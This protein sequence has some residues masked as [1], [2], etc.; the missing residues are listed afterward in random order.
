MLKQ[1]MKMQ[2]RFF[3]LLRNNQKEFEMKE[4]LYF[5]AKWCGPCKQLSPV[6]E[7]LSKTYS[8][9]LGQNYPIKKIDIDENP[10][11][12]EKFNVKGVP[13]II[14]IKDGNEQSRLVGLNSKK[15]YIEEF[16][17]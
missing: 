12:T 17:K 14:I 16:E 3:K 5:T 11:Y 7:E 8:M 15:K 2:T 1:V 6:I 10:E 4:I 9:I 13:T